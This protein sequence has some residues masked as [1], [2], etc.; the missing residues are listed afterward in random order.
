MSFGDGERVTPV[1]ANNCSRD[2]MASSS[3]AVDADDDADA[4]DGDTLLSLIKTV[5]KRFVTAVT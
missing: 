4:E 3:M 2:G 5:R 1:V